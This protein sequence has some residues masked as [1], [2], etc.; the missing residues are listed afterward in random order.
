MAKVRGRSLKRIP[1][2][3][4][5]KL[6]QIRSL[7]IAVMNGGMV[8]DIDPA[9]IKDNQASLLVNARVRR[10][11]T[12]RRFG[13][14]SFLPTKPNSN[15]VIRLFDFKV[16]DTTFYRIRFTASD[17][18]F[19]DEASWTQLIGTFSGRPTDIA[20]VLGTLV[21]A[22]GVDKLQKLDLD[23]ETIS[24]LG[25][26]APVSKYVTGF[27]ER[28]VGA[29]NGNSDAAAES[30]AWSGNRNLDEFDALKDIS[31]GNK[32]LDTSPRTVVDPI[33]GVFGFSSVMIIPRERSIWLATQNP[34]AS[35]PF[36]TFRAV[37]GVGTDLSGSIAIGKEK[38]IFLDARTRDVIVYSPGRPIESIGSPIRDSILANITDPG[39]LRSTY[40]EYEDEYYVTITEAST[41]KVWVVNF[42]TNSWQYDEVPNLTSIDALT[43]FSSYTSFDDATG[44]FDS[45][46]GTF[47]AASVTP[48]NIPTLIYGYSDGVILKEDS[49]VQQDNSVNYTFELRSKEFEI[50]K[51]DIVITRIL[52]KYQA[53]VS[54]TLT[55]AFSK[56]GGTTW[57][58]AKAHTTLTGKVRRLKFQ[59]QIRTERLMWRLTAT[60]GQFDILG[61][62]VDVSAG[63]ETKGG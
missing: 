38:I 23:A 51:E 37:P 17:I 48:I 52:I 58:T 62:E 5:G 49:S 40:F 22:N 4:S 19:T 25:S 31:S 21:V 14:S 45:A 33:R 57:I 15:A 44:D 27:S 20:T 53:T 46:S 42:R 2:L 60:G 8:A 56:D 3:R 59:K 61:Y 32:R 26:I 47:D 13:K 55:L 30:I 1:G 29:N 10:D 28:V 16:G 36:N 63:G 54:D 41:V 6:P 35:D 18:Y 7:A 43:L 11:K 39:A 50:V 12:T 9:D 34:I 24:D